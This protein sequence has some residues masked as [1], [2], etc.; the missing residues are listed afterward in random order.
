[1]VGAEVLYFSDECCII[2]LAQSPV[3]EVGKLHTTSEQ[4]FVLRRYGGVVL[5]NWTSMKRT[6]VDCT[7]TAVSSEEFGE[8]SVEIIRNEGGDNV[9]FTIRDNKKMAGTNSIEIVL[10]SRTWVNSW[11]RAVRA[12][13]LSLCISFHRFSFQCFNLGLLVQNHGH[14]RNWGRGTRWNVFDKSRN[15]GQGICGVGRGGSWGHDRH[16]IMEM[17]GRNG[18]WFRTGN[19]GAVWVVRI[20]VVSQFGPGIS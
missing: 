8:S 18:K 11:L 15:D 20:N 17:R 16:A 5:S 7:T 2:F 1:V 19:R 9:L 12:W 3:N 6:G 14:G 13:S 10:P 4:K